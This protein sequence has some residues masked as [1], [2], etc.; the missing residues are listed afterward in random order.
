VCDKS[1]IAGFSA[2]QDA[3]GGKYCLASRRS[4]ESNSPIELKKDEECESKVGFTMSNAARTATN[5]EHKGTHK[6]KSMQETQ[7]RMFNLPIEIDF[8]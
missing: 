3:V 6:V 5:R 7:L 8:R 2:V 4:K 1:K